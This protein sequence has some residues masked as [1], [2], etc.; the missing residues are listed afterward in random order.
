MGLLIVAVQLLL[1]ELL[2]L[3]AAL[4]ASLLAGVLGVALESTGCL[5]WTDLSLSLRWAQNVPILWAWLATVVGFVLAMIALPLMAVVV[6]EVRVVVPIGDCA[7]GTR[8]VGF[9]AAVAVVVVAP[10]VSAAS[11]ERWR[12]SELIAL[13]AAFCRC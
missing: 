5:R 6:L 11:D 8:L 2:L 10:V 1:V 9:T 12:R 3:L 4:V 7:F 13:E